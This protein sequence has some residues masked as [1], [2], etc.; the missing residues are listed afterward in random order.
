MY[1]RSNNNIIIGCFL[2]LGFLNRAIIMQSF[3][4]GLNFYFTN[5]VES[6]ILFLF[7]DEF[8]TKILF[9][10][11]TTLFRNKRFMHEEMT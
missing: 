7:F 10:D 6:Q 4:R 3:M 2:E 8:F 5:F 11:S 9:V 1:L